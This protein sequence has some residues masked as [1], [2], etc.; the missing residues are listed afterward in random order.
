MS[1]SGITTM[2]V[3]R[4]AAE[5]FD[6]PGEMARRCREFDWTR[7]PLGPVPTWSQSLRVSVAIVLASRHPMFLWWGPNLIQIF[8][9]GYLPS[10]GGSGRD[11]A[12]LGAKGREHWAE[13]WPVIGP[14]IESIM[15]GGTASWHEDQLVPIT[16]NGRVEDV[17]WTYGY[18]PVRDDDGSVGGVLVIVQETTTRVLLERR[19]AEL[20]AELT[21][22]RARLTDVFHQA[23]AF[24]A[25]LRGR[26][27]VVEMTNRDYQQLIGHRDVVGKRLMQALPELEG[28]GFV[29]LL[30]GVMSTGTP[31]VGRE[32]PVTLARSPNEPPEERYLTF[33]YAPLTEPDGSRSGIFVHGVDVS[34]HVFAR[35]RVDATNVQLRAAQ[36]AAE[37]ANKAKSEFLAVMSH[38]LRTPLNAIG[39]YVELL[40][41]GL[42][43]PVTPEQRQ[44]LA[45]IQQ[46]QKHLLGLINQV[47]NHTQLER[48]TVQYRLERVLVVELLL[49]AETLA[50]PQIEA[51]R[52]TYAR[53]ECDPTLAVD[54]DAEKAVQVLVNL[55]TNATKF[56]RVGEIRMSCTVSGGMARI[57]VCDTG[58][59]IGAD[60]LA[61]IFE[62]FVQID[63]RLSRTSEGVGLG[64]AISRDLAR[65]MAGDL[66]ADSVLGAGS[67]FVLSLP[68]ASVS[69]RAEQS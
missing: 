26:D 5:L 10:F 27:Y 54:A 36:A 25:V 58:I 41:L 33:V 55:L 49:K 32:T 20:L 39:G 56:T 57:A 43:G 15:A 17:W 69:L 31:Y 28:Q 40:D 61:S 11:V 22:E 38:E 60:R 18:S 62:P 44:D 8:N 9:D 13:I 29:E 7:T 3:L 4:K 6:Q 66:T 19:Q 59:G 23:P 1:G 51:K 37:A 63:V 14:E 45:R 2:S 50:K 34:E 24:I 30:D 53:D 42:H 65:G 12:A 64:L 68:V 47:L 67:T 52:L 21:I 16:R 48:G 35:A 46:S